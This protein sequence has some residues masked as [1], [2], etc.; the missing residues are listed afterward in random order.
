MLVFL[1]VRSDLKK[2][3]KTLS[4]LRAFAVQKLWNDKFTKLPTSRA[5]AIFGWVACATGID[6]M[7]NVDGLLPKG[8]FKTGLD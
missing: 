8:D 3:K 5:G 2:T 1:I 7:S 4:V 6:G